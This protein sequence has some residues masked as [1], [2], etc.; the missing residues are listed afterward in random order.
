[1]QE[2]FEGLRA[3]VALSCRIL[4]MLGL[5]KEVTG[6]LDASG[7]LGFHSFQLL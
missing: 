1:M 4:A 6:Q 5:V 3:K 2:A 7:G